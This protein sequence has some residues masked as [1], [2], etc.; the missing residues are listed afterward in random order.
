MWAVVSVAALPL[1]AD[2]FS[3]VV[4]FALGGFAGVG[5]IVASRQPRNAIG[6]MLLAIAI[7]VS[8]SNV[9]E[10]LAT[11]AANP[12]DVVMWLD[13]WLSDV[14]IALVGVWIP[15]LFPNGHLPSGRGGPWPG[16]GPPCSPSAC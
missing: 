14:S 11:R 10:A 5:A 9:V 6:W 13:E 2:S 16:S 3:V 12:A 4:T 1:A 8:L 15:L 7:V